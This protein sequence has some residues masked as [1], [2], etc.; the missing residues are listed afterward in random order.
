[1]ISFIAAVHTLTI[2]GSSNPILAGETPTLTCNVCSD[3]LPSVKWINSQNDEMITV[4]GEVMIGAPVFDGDNCT[5]LSLTFNS[6]KTSQGG[7]YTCQS[8]VDSPFSEKK[9]TRDIIVKS[10]I[11]F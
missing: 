2:D 11:V 4:E 8:V 3:F 7:R 1:M 9:S 10:E 5:S 6:L